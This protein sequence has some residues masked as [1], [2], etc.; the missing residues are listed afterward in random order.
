MWEKWYNQLDRKDFYIWG[1]MLLGLLGAEITA[2]VLIPVWK[3]YFFDGI[4]AKSYE[5]FYSGLFYFVI[6]ITV[7]VVSQGFKYY[8]SHRFSLVSREALIKVL[9]ERWTLNKE[10]SKKLDYPDQRIQ[11]D[12][13]LVTELTVEVAIEVV[14]SSLIIVGLVAQMWGNWL[15]LGL[16]IGYT[17]AVTLVALLFHR[18]MIDTEKWLQR[19]EAGF[20]FELAKKVMGK[21]RIRYKG[22]FHLVKSAY[23]RYTKVL[24]GFTLFNRAK[25]N[26]MALVPYLV[27]VPMYFAGDITFGRIMEGVSQ[28]ELLVINASILIILYP[29]VTK[30]IASYERISEFYNKLGGKK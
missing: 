18:P 17:I 15:L 5:I 21:T 7:F 24:M 3:N 22:A 11:E 25:S 14:I 16:G 4:E 30:A 26:L 2:T 8:V 29:R 19:K 1:V 13:R 27:L 20:R 23:L 6:L 28:F 9:Y 10:D 12:S